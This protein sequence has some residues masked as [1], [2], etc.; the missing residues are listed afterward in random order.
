MQRTLLQVHCTAP[1]P[2]TKPPT[3][4]S[5]LKHSLAGHE[6]V[7]HFCCPRLF[8]QKLCS[9]HLM[10]THTATRTINWHSP[11]KHTFLTSLMVSSSMSALCSPSTNT[12]QASL[13]IDPRQSRL[14]APWPLLLANH[15]VSTC[16][17]LDLALFSNERSATSLG[18]NMLCSF[19]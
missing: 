7:L 5:P 17:S 19:R 9:P 8:S 10:N 2:S 3:T 14:S 1:G 6:T 11:R 13:P 15:T 18:E 4:N 16:T 12:A